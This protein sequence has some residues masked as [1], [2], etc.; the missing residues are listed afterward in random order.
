MADEIPYVPDIFKS[1]VKRVSDV[2]ND[3]KKDDPFKV[4]FDYGIYTDVCKN[5]DATNLQNYFLVWLVMPFDTVRGKDYSVYG[6]IK[7]QLII[8]TPTDP[9]YT[10]QEKEIASFKPRLIPIYKELLEQ[11]NAEKLFSTMSVNQIKHQRKDWPYW[12][13]GDVA[14]PGA[15]NLFKNYIDAIAVNDLSLKVKF[16][17]KLC[18]IKKK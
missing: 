10:M 13:G 1:V 17:K 11:I 9:N 3:P 2:L 7:C 4:A 12:G 6:D 5:I 15:K 8:A 18:L 14:G 16:E